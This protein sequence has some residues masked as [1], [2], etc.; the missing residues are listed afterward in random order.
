MTMPLIKICGITN[1]EDALVSIEAGADALGF[2]FYKK[3]PRYIEP[4][5]AREIIERL[6]VSVLNV[7][8][9]VNENSPEDVAGIAQEVKL[10]AVQLHGEESPEYCAGLK[11]YHVIKAFRVS[12]RFKSEDVLKFK[13]DSILLDTYSREAQGGTGEIFDWS[14]AAETQNL[15]PKVF[16]AGG[17]AP[18]NIARAIRQVNPYAVDVCSGLE[19][20][21]GKKDARKVQAFIQAVRNAENNLL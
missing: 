7:G 5:K 16:L 1:L 12:P 2:N 9:F 6:P 8:V 17:L 3:S 14:I 15:F 19:V 21:N 20:I 10:N 18:E 4:V 11:S 13:V